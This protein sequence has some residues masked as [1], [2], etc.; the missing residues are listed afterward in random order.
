[1]IPSVGA[2][3][4]AGARWATPA[5]A[6]VL[7]V[8]GA[9]VRVRTVLH[10]G[11]LSVGSYDDG[12]HYAVAASLLQGR[13]PYREVLFLQ[14]PGMAVFAAPAALVGQLFGDAAGLGTARIAVALLGGVNTALVVLIL[15]RLGRTGAVCGGA[16]YAMSFSA[17]YV[18]RS[19]VLEAPGTTGLLLS[20]LLA[21]RAAATGRGR[22]WLLAGASAG[23]TVGL[24]IWYLI[25][26]AVLLAGARRGRL[27][28][29]VGGVVAGAAVY[30]P[31][32]VAAPAR[33]W[34][35]VVV[36]Q[37]T[38]PDDGVGLGKR[39]RAVLGVTAPGQ[40]TPI[41]GVP[42]REVGLV[43]LV[44][45]VAMVVLALTDRR[46]RLLV[47]LLA[48]C[49]VLLLATPSFFQHYTALAAAPLALVGGAGAQRAA[50]LLRGR[51]APLAVVAIVVVLAVSVNLRH[52]GRRQG[53]RPPVSALRAAV[54]QVGGCVM[55]DDPTVLAVVDRLT[56]DLRAGCPMQAD[57]SG[58]GYLLPDGHGSRGAQRLDKPAFQREIVR[59]L[60]SGSAYLWTRGDGLQVTPATA[61]RLRS[62][63]VLFQDGRW[64][65]RAVVR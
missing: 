56:P 36:A 32:F 7:G 13:L 63:P 34:D 17:V 24:K 11:L 37:L 57:P 25:P 40:T 44:L 12:V 5:L 22:W 3:R 33:M 58:I 10:S 42:G 62:A 50:A 48:A 15:A 26:F 39:V 30:L 8:A 59:Y 1:M 35:Q 49:G 20:L 46:A 53:E 52:D 4:S 2:M 21:Q 55:A 54:Q 29:L 51:W 43:L 65:L 6:I 64:V 19:L 18:E 14:P 16:L 47:A 9:L 23:L 27:R 60:R 41:A 38:R 61:A 31:F 45:A 28:F